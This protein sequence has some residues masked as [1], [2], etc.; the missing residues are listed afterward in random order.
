MQGGPHNN[1]TAAIALTFKLVQAQSFKNYQKQI[2][3]NSRALA[4]ALKKLGFRLTTNGTDN[5]LMILDLRNNGIS[6]ME[7]ENLLEKAGIMAN[8]NVVVGDMSPFHPSGI[9]IGTPAVTT[10]G[11]KE[12]EMKKIAELISRV[13]IKKEKPVIIKKEIK[14]LCSKFPIYS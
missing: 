11:M 10:R 12:K 4:E 1:V 7:A 3:K 6:G 5:H 13:L 14:K 8:R 9:R 2:L